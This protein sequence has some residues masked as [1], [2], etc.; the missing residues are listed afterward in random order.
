MRKEWNG[1]LVGKDEW[2]EKHPQLEPLRVPP[3]PQAIKGA[4]PEPNLNQE[5]NIQWSWNPVG[6]PSDTDYSNNNLKMVGS[7]GSVTVSTT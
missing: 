3:D 7:V 1:L 5:R 2:E 4:R 6:G